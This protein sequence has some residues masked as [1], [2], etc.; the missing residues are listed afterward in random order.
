M[1]TSPQPVV[2]KS[3][4]GFDS[5]TTQIELNPND[6]ETHHW[7]A[8]SLLTLHRLPEALTQIEIARNL[9]PT[10]P[11]VLADRALI[12]Y[13][14]GESNKGLA[15]LEE[16]RR[17]EPDFLSPHRYL[18]DIFRGVN[19]DEGFITEIKRSG[20]LS[21]DAQEMDIADAAATGWERNGERGM[22]E[23]MYKVEKKYFDEGQASG[24][25]LART[26]IQLSRKKEAVHYLQA[27]FTAHVI[28]KIMADHLADR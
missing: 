9:N 27:A 16:L 19:D 18:A 23:A 7:F 15:E 25:E 11:S 2:P 24:Y 17:A 4:V 13:W 14:S 3:H 21:K 28:D 1:S 8:T 22:L 10:S 12:I 26:C 6:V 20:T 5:I